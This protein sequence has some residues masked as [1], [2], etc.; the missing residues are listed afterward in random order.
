MGLTYSASYTGD[1]PEA[2][3]T[4]TWTVTPNAGVTVV[5][6]GDDPAEVKV[7]FT[8]QGSVTSTAVKCVITDS[9][10]SDSGAN[11]TLTVVPHFVIGAV[12]ITGPTS[13]T[14]GVQS[15]VYSI[16]GYTGQSN[17]VPNDLTYAWT[18]SGAGAF[19][20]ATSA[21]PKFTPSAAG[22]CQISCI[23][24]SAKSDPTSSPKSN[25]ISA[26]VAA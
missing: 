20:S 6:P 14:N 10:A 7:T 17:P 15:A 2:D 8:T 25:V 5:A 22:G 23:V 26:S 3:V 16:T 11:D 24:S 21:T 19:D 4:Y 1:A 9:D 13:L 18:A 12:S